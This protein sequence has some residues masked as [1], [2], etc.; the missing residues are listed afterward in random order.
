MVMV[1]VG[2]PLQGRDLLAYH[3]VRAEKSPDSGDQGLGLGSQGGAFLSF[4]KE[5]EAYLLFQGFHHLC[6]AGL[7]VAQG[8]ARPGEAAVI[9]DGQHNFP[10]FNI[11][12][13]LSFYI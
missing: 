6:D 7:G 4:Y 10:S 9:V 11:H 1:P 3:L 12:S 13:L 2:R 8:L 5:R